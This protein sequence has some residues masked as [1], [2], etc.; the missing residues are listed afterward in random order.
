MKK[1]FKQT[2]AAAPAPLLIFTIFAACILIVLLFG[3][4]IYQTFTERDRTGYDH[5]TIA[6]YI[7]TRVR[8][9]DGDTLPFVG[10]FDETDGKE[11]GNTFFIR[12]KLGDITC[13][14]RLYCH[15]GYLY[16]LFAPDGMD[17]EPAD[18]EQVLPLNALTFRMD[19]DLLFTE[20]E[21]PDGSCETLILHL[22]S[23]KE[24]LP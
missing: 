13:L 7:T 24:V 1:R 20:I 3:A 15:D 14:T 6:Q 22:R 2:D 16:E 11:A 17:F 19:G 18:G 12:E 21:Y 10:D 9:S 8:Q 23:K 5:R 4:N